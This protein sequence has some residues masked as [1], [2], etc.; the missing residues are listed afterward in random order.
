MKQINFKKVESAVINDSHRKVLAWFFAYPTKEISLNDLTKLVHISKTTANK[1]VTWLKKEGFLKIDI[2][3]NLWRL[4]CN[5]KHIFNQTRKIPYHLEL[6]Y[7]SEIIEL[8]LSRIQNARAII[9]FGSY[10]KGDDIDSSDLDIAVEVLDT[11]NIKM[12]QIG[13]IPQLGYRKNVKVNILIFSRKKVDVNLFSNIA[14][15]IILHGFLEVKP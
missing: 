5:Q 14:N 8:I 3:G 13:I 10:R 4:S 7:Q 2:L 1:T 15:G 9:L 6:I 12:Q 11:E